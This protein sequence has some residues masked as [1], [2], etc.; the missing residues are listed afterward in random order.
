MENQIIYLNGSYVAKED[1]VISIYDHGFLYGDGVFE[2]IR[3]YE[4]NVY[5]LTEHVNRLYESAHSIMLEIPHK[6]EEMAEII[7]ETIR[8]NKLESAYIRVVVSRGVGDLGLDPRN[9]A[10]PTVIVIAEELAIYANDLY[11]KGL[12]LASVGYR[13]SSPDV[14]NPQIK[15]LNYL[16][17]ILVKLSSIQSN[18]DEA[19]ILN[20]Q[21]FVTEG[22]ADN[23]FIVKNSV[24]KTPPIYL[25]ALEG[26]T[27]NAIIDIAKEQG[28]VVEEVPFTLHD[29]YT[30]DEVFLTGT[31]AE[32]IPVV[33]VDNR[34]IGSGYPDV[35]TKDL[36]HAF[37]QKTLI[38][39]V[40]C[41]SKNL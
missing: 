10:T 27:R 33:A 8:K 4:G 7:I 3:A 17:N 41:Y 35:I 40:H 39:G 2:G 13:R 11:E 15:S 37:R 22:S 14:L 16:N 38:D 23:I 20:N 6:K 29:V 32:V 9:C 5:K 24:I 34:K 28:Y 21:G 31:A 18:A 1:A 26:I 25:G 36:L 12:K 30:A 19:L